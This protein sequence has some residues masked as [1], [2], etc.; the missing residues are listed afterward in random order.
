ME[1]RHSRPQIP[2]RALRRGSSCCGLRLAQ[3]C[4]AVLWPRNK[5]PYELIV[6]AA[7]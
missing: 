6:T 3:Y 5:L 2:Q 1:Y 7:E 4:S